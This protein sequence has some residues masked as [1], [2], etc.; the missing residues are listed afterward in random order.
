M[1]DYH[2]GTGE[3][4]GEIYAGTLSKDKTKWQNRTLVTDEAVCAVR[5]HLLNKLAAENLK[6][7][8]Y[9]WTRKDGK[10][11]TLQVSIE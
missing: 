8:G 3:I 4:S 5:D 11:V 10:K 1:A 9:E 7:Y 2:V 6:Q